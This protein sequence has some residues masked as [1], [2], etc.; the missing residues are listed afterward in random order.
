MPMM[1]ARWPAALSAMI[2]MAAAGS[3]HAWGNTGH[4][5]I[6]TLAVQALPATVPAFLRAPAVAAQVGELSREPD[7]SRGAGKVHDTLRDPGHFVDIDEDGRILGGPRFDALPPTITDYDT[8]LRASGSDIAKA[9]YLPYQLLDGWQQLTKDLALWRVADHGA[10]TERA[11]QRRAWLLADKA[12]REQLVVRDLGTWSHF[13]GDASYPLHVS[14]HFNG[15]GDGPNPQGF[16]T[17]R[18]HVP[19][20]GSFVR[21]NVVVS[22]VRAAM[23]PYQDCACPIEARLTAYLGDSWRLVTPFYLL[24]KQGGFRDDDPRGTQFVTGRLAVAAAQVRDLTIAAWK[25]SEAASVG[26]PAITLAEVK[27]G[28]ASAYDVLYS[29]GD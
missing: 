23:P 3:A 4:R 17:Q 29:S 27:A 22:A 24:E 8:A 12:A 21:R 2:L 6:G 7:R 16:T 26:Y 11:P 20:E 14:S 10:R 18:I 25:A 28:K 9:G 15:W 5:M 13:V 19:I 1:H